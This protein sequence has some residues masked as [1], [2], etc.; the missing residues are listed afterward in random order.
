MP[1]LAIVIA[2]TPEDAL[3]YIRE[4][5]PLSIESILEGTMSPLVEVRLRGVVTVLPIKTQ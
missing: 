1:S 3:D 5:T 2:S 4:A